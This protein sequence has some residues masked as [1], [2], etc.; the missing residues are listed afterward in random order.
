MK[1]MFC[2]S[3][4]IGDGLS[5]KTAFRPHF[6]DV[7]EIAGH[8]LGNIGTDFVGNVF[9]DDQFVLDA[10]AA[11]PLTEFVI[12]LEIKG[13]KLG[14]ENKGADLPDDL[15][16]K[17][18]SWIAKMGLHKLDYGMKKPG[19]VAKHIMTQVSG[20]EDVDPLEGFRIHWS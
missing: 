10:I 8:S 14:W 18:T 4:R 17:I 3:K 5:P 6:A 11:D 12:P 19:Q 16:G 15:Q 13:K 2:T 7:P 20:I 1:A 9:S